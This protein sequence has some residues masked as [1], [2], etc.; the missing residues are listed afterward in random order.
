MSITTLSSKGRL[1][2]PKVIRQTARLVPGAQLSVTYEDGEIRLRP[3]STQSTTSLN[4]VAGCLARPRRKR[5]N[6][7]ET[8][9]AIKTRQAG[10]QDA[11]PPTVIV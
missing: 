3:L 7:Q 1:V 9:T 8:R 6:E 11:R 10:K 4:E 2:I 5:L